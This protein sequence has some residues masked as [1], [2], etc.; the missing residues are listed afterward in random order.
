[1]KKLLPYLAWVII[2]SCTLSAQLQKATFLPHW[3]PQAQFAGYY[4]ALEK[5]LYKKYGLDLEIITN[6]SEGM[7]LEKMKKADFT[8]LWLSNAIEATDEGLPLVNIAQL[9]NKSSLMLVAK[10][11]SGIK[12]PEDLNFKK[13]SLWGGGFRIQPNAFF[14]KYK[15]NVNTVWQGNTVNLFLYD[16]VSASTAMWYNE[17]H[18]ILNSGINPDE[19]TTFMFADYGLNIPEDG[20]YCLE[21]TLRNKPEMCRA[22]VKATLEG[23]K[24]VFENEQ[25]ALNITIRFIKNAGLPVNQAHE[26]WMLRCMKQLIFPNGDPNK[27]QTLSEKDF[28]FCIKGLLEN[29]MISKPP[30]FR[31]FYQPVSF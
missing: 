27:F 31:Q 26:K 29:K 11:S 19:L 15:L 20:I 13:I 21:S 8:S 25:E 5:G 10:K 4:V 18:T 30:V 6:N 22:F 12:N 16:A 24:M 2:L 17:Y 1:M 23:W 7:T 14:N 9:I 28:N 3:V